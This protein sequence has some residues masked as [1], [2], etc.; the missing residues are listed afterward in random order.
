[1]PIAFDRY[2]LLIDGR[3]AFIRSGAMHYFRL[4]SVD[5]WRD[6]L[7]R[8]RMGGY[9]AVDLYFN[10]AFHSQRPGSYDFTGIRDV[11]RLLELACEAG[12]Y[13]IARPGPYINA[14]LSGGGLPAWLLADRNVIP[15]NR[16]PD[17]KF[18]WSQPYMDAVAEWW[19][20]ITPKIARCENLILMQIE[21]EYATEEMEPD[22]L[23]ALARMSRD[24]GAQVPLFHNDLYAAGLYEDVVDIYA[25]DNYSVTSFETDWR[26]NP[27]T[28]GVIDGAEEA[29]RPFCAH[30][31][32]FAAELQAG[33][34]SGR[35]GPSTD[36]IRARLGRD[37]LALSVKSL[38][39]QGQRFSTIIWQS[40]EAIGTGSA[41]RMLKPRMISPRP[42]QKR[43]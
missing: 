24:L 37:H 16:L 2:S 26:L 23:L 29:F 12:L 21:N 13:V 8:L 27:Q 32:L 4:P 10:W 40:A 11:D 42:S 30:R 19:G 43:V 36:T 1:M 15:R 6:R 20:Q 7:A 9:N 39:A 3:R 34:F 41:V 31:P 25:F 35:G 18:K 17:G 33:W 5:L 28:F 14:E 22:Y 38:L